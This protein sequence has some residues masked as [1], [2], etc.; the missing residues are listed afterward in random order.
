MKNRNIKEQEG[1][2]SVL[3]DKEFREESPT[4]ARNEVEQQMLRDDFDTVFCR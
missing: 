4:A 2:Y 1:W 3:T